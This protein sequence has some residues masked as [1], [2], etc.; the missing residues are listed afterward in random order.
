MPPKSSID[1]VQRLI[2]AEEGRNRIIAAAR[3]KKTAKVRQAKT[4]AERAVADFRKEKD[5]ELA[6]HQ[7][8][9][10]SAVNAEKATVTQETEKQIDALRKV[11]NQR[12]DR[13]A[14]ILTGM[15]CNVELDQKAK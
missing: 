12:T 5:G 9:L 2:T 11:A 3:Q 10:T 13:V 6:R 14:D 1:Y 8:V 7:D 15:I 4:D